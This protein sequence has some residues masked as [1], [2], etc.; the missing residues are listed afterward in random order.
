ML[1]E[2]LA[3]LR[4]LQSLARLIAMRPELRLRMGDEDESGWRINWRTGVITADRLDMETRSPDYCR[5]LILHEAAH[6]AITRWHQLVPVALFNDPGIRELLN[7]VEDARIETWLGRRHPGSLPWIREYNDFNFRDAFADEQVRHH[8][9]AAFHFGL[10]GRWWYGHLPDEWPAA[11]RDAV[12]RVWDAFTRVLEL[13]PPTTVDGLAAMARSYGEHPVSQRCRAPR[14]GNERALVEAAARMTQWEAWEIVHREI[15]PVFEELRA[16]EPVVPPLFRR[17][18]IAVEGS[19]TGGSEHGEGRGPA[20]RSG[21]PFKPKPARHSHPANADLAYEAVV[22]DLSREIDAVSDDLLRRLVAETRPQLRRHLPSGPRLDLAVA[23]QFEADPRLHNRLW[24]RRTLPQRPDPHF[25]ILID[26]SGS[27]HGERIRSAQAAAIL[28]REVSLRVG[29]AL[30]LITFSSAAE[31]LQTWNTPQ[32]ADVRHRLGNLPRSVGGSTNLAAGLHL[33]RQEFAESSHRE[34]FLWIISDGQ[35]HD[36][37]SVKTLIR[38]LAPALTA[39]LG[40]GMGAGTEALRTLLP[41]AAT[42]I[43][44]RQLPE[45]VGHLLTQAL[46][47]EATR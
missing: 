19:D 16:G 37:E 22:A 39:V 40:L 34:R 18:L 15:L 12:E 4:E 2:Q 28:L 46:G 13:H 23:M 33:A 32:A 10:L 3:F 29:I 45:A 38:E 17:R 44:P 43:E 14:P 21:N 9:V 36:P 27:M 26:T 47:A 42:A 41:H 5:G 11:A 24:Q 7:V 35:P 6:A 1:T 20:V 31:R 25:T 8:K 30:S